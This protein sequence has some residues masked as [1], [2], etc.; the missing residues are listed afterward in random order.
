MQF[1]ILAG[2]FGK[3]VM[4]LSLF[5]PKPVFPLDGI[6]LLHILLDQLEA[7][8]LTRGF[9]NTHHLPGMVEECARAWP[10]FGGKLNARFLYEKELSGSRI[11]SAAVDELENN[12]PLLS[13]NGD[14]FMEIPLDAMTKEMEKGDVDGVL[15]A[16]ENFNPKY[17]GLLTDENGFFT[18][19]KIH[20]KSK[21][22]DEPA[23]MY[24]GAAMFKRHVLKHFKDRSFFD[25]LEQ[26]ELRFNLKV[27][28]YGGPWLDI[29]S[30]ASY[31][32]ADNGYKKYKGT[33]AG[34]SFSANVTV[35]G[36][37]TVEGS[38]IW[39]NTEIRGGSVIRNCVVTGNMILD[40]VR[41]ENQS[42]TGKDKS[43]P[44]E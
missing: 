29:G 30:P 33:G 6:P 31:L 18:V 17:N 16:R 24:T 8:G 15:V 4:P 13:L 34:N 32:E 1:F 5:K 41:Y 7:A 36:D 21:P 28:A 20:D 38:V 11:L 14:T 2:G 26:R 23:L 42:V 22:L 3:R 10:G 43:T 37:S 25:S 39:E 44:L 12:E 27:L 19:R 40:G 9:I 35:S